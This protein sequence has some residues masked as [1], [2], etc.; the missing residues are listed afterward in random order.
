MANQQ[1]ML[2]NEM[3]LTPDPKARKFLRRNGKIFLG[4]GSQAPEFCS[5]KYTWPGSS[6]GRAVD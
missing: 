1:T 4:D 6:V 5:R 3:R 2:I